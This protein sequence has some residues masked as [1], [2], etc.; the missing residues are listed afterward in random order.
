MGGGVRDE[1]AWASDD[2]SLIVGRLGHRH[3]VNGFRFRIDEVRRLDRKPIGR[4]AREHF[5]A[6]LDAA[7]RG[8]QMR[9]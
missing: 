2:R 7:A 3:L 6:L 1:L 9:R 4:I 8:T 5:A